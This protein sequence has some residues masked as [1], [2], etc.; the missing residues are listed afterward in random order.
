MNAISTVRLLG[1]VVLGSFLALAGCGES[2]PGPAGPGAY[3]ADP[4]D[5]LDGNDEPL[6]LGKDDSVRRKLP[7]FDDLWASYAY[8]EPE[9]VKELIGGAVNADWITNT[10]VVR[11]SR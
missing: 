8:G 7:A 1:A 11:V 6:A 3:S 2:G 5:P 10:C 9:D 4:L